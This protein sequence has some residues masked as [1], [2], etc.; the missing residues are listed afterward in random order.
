MG[1]KFISVFLAVIVLALIAGCA[2]PP[3]AP[4]P[5][6]PPSSETPSTPQP[7]PYQTPSVSETPTPSPE[8]AP[9]GPPSLSVASPKPGESV[10]GPSVSLQLAIENFDLVAPG[11]AN[12]ANQ[13]HVRVLLDNVL[14]T[15]GVSETI[16][17]ESV[18]PTTH[19]ALIELRNNDGTSLS[20]A[21][22]QTLSF[23]VLEKAGGMSSEKL[24]SV[25]ILSPKPSQVVHGT[26]VDVVVEATNF[27]L[28][29]PGTAPRDGEGYFQVTL[30]SSKVLTGKSPNFKFEGVSAGQHSLRVELLK[31]NGSFLST[32][33]FH[34]VS[35]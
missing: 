5:S 18:S 26:A 24:P 3:A 2:Q 25:Q 14:E 23:A 28:V 30:D 1:E 32:S 33:A 13:G 27:L 4:E 19:K 22:V 12:K 15:I 31:A 16:V 34:E 6:P 9:S 21:V 11:G 35:F 7:A 29:E 8:S 10:V 17:L 20:P